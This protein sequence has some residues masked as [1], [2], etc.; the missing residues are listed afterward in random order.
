MHHKHIHAAVEIA[1]KTADKAEGSLK[2]VKAISASEAFRRYDWIKNAP[3]RNTS[4][5]LRGMVIS[6]RWAAVFHFAEDA[7]KPVEKIALFAALADNLFK[8]RQQTA[9]ILDSADSWDTKAARLS[10]QVSSVMLRTAG[11]AIS[12]TADLLAT[13]LGGYCQI[14]ELAG[15]QRATDLD[16]RLKTMAATFN[17][18]FEKIT[19]G[20]NIYIYINKYLVIN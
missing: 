9:A 1:D 14:G 8:A 15:I 19:D 10:T 3:V 17:S 7:L 2:T 11:G 13:I 16:E 12:A 5:N 6:K 4:N 20:D 18:R